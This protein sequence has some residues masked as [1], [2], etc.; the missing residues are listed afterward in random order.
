MEPHFPHSGGPVRGTTASAEEIARF[1]AIADAWWDPN[2]AF[3]LLHQLNPV[4]VGYIRDVAVRHFGR[5][6]LAT[7]PLQGLSLIDI[8]CGGGLASESLA[9]LGAAVVGIDASEES[10]RVAELHARREHLDVQYRC[11]AP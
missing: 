2:G 9:R 7:R 5:D 1:S 10:V 8:G 6:P 11:A 4:R 3:R